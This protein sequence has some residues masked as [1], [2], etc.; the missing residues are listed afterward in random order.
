MGG[1]G[2]TP[3]TI[4]LYNA[5]RKKK[6]AVVRK[7]HKSHKDEINLTNYYVD[8]FFVNKSRVEGIKEA[9]RKNSKLIILDDGMQDPNI[10]ADINIACFKSNKLIGNELT[11]PAGPLRE[12]LS[13]IK[14]CNFVV[15]NGNKN[16]KFENKLLQLQP[17]IK[18]YYSR[19]SSLNH[20]IFKGK[21]VL[22]FCG[23]GNSNDFFHILEKN[24]IKI[25]KKVSFPDHYELKDEDIKKL[26]SD[27]KK[28]KLIL[29]TTEKDYFRI[30]N[31]DKR[32]IKFLKIKLFI[33]KEKKFFDDIKK[34][35]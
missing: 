34:F 6:A 27:A 32:N 14:K 4:K 22:A 12:S 28:E 19:Y 26:N 8:D 24:K 35:L 31:K 7:F 16:K 30:R 33:E 10:S 9:I 13:S 23:I 18:I 15:I 5:F 21:K 29:L 3:L 25:M 17:Y 20:K 2:K 11:L 1:T